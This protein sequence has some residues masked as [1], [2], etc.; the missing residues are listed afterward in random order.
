MLTWEMG[1]VVVIRFSTSRAALWHRNITVW[2]LQTCF[3]VR[4]LPLSCYRALT[5]ISGA[6]HLLRK[7]SA[8]FSFS[9]CYGWKDSKLETMFSCNSQTCWK[10]KGKACLTFHWS[11]WFLSLFALQI[12]SS[13][14]WQKGRACVQV[15][16]VCFHTWLL[17]SHLSDRE[18]C[19]LCAVSAVS[20][21]A[22]L[23][24]S[25]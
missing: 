25:Q 4:R 13:P 19:T 17:S 2:K 23:P 18:W 24:V 11:Q 16:V 8:P 5:G 14:L 7:C 21:N 1:H 10:T 12:T 3:S 20:V 15:C 6:L 9:W 22:F